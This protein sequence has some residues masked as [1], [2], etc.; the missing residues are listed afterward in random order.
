M[1]KD[2]VTLLNEYGETLT[3]TVEAGK[4]VTLPTLTMDGHYFQGWYDNNGN[5]VDSYTATTDGS[6]KVTYT[7]R[8]EHTYLE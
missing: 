7:A 4:T 5:K 6:G 1:A 2:T 8:W 3:I